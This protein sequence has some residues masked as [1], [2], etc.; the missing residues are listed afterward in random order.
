MTV[1]AKTDAPSTNGISPETAL[2]SDPNRL[3]EPVQVHIGV[4]GRYEA[5]KLR[6][7]WEN[8][9]RGEERLLES[10][11][12][13][14]HS[15][16]NGSTPG[17]GSANGNSGSHRHEI[18]IPW[19]EYDLRGLS[20]R[21]A[22]TWIDSFLETDRKQKVA[23]SR[24]SAFRVALIGVDEQSCKLVWSL[25]PSL[26]DRID[27]ARIIGRFT[28]TCGPEIRIETLSANGDGNGKGLVK[29]LAPAVEVAEH[30]KDGL[31]EEE[32]IRVSEPETEAKSE[33]ETGVEDDVIQQLRPVWEAVLKTSPVGLDEDFFDLGGHSLLAARLLV[34][35]EQT[36]GVELPLAS[37]LEAPTIRAQ[38]RLIR[39]GRTAKQPT[40]TQNASS[41]LPFFFF[42]G[43]PTFRPLCR[44]LSELRPLHILGLQGSLIAKLKKP[45][46]EAIG[47]QFVKMIQE[48]QPDGPYMLAGWCAHGLLAFEAAR[49]LKAQGQAVAQV[50]MLETVNPVRWRQYS[51]WRRIVGRWQLK[52][53]LL[54]FEL[55]YL[56]E[57][58]GRQTKDYLLARGAQKLRRLRNSFGQRLGM[59][60]EFDESDM[61][62]PVDVLYDAAARYYPKPYQGSVVLIRSIDRTLGFGRHLQ[63]GW[64]DVLEGQLEVS[65]TPGNHY[66]IYMGAN[67]D[68][69]AQTMH[70][71]LKKAEQAL[72]KTSA[73]A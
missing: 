20:G 6:S 72:S 57:V 52:M 33:P 36:L 64:D 24:R 27:V 54:R 50:V 42:G 32:A 13:N 48:R 37:L 63:L 17:N 2:P 4:S 61:W 15:Q 53:H 41:E 47:E 1:T 21:E 22:Q 23:A 16:P 38:A 73:A 18:H 56:R 35:V 43:D 44:R 46:L 45:T 28:A 39:E 9:L 7:A 5:T 60:H 59:A 8:T 30:R 26:A 68:P 69:L 29:V 10:S 12:V 65:E 25:H 51:G 11:T 55:A 67:V 31:H 40:K 49:Q 34:R 70:S 14:G 62:N 58:N 71:Y 19:Q 66:S 3:S